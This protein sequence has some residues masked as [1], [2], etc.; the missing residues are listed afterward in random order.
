MIESLQLPKQKVQRWKDKISRGEKIAA[1]LEFKKNNIVELHIID[2]RDHVFI[3]TGYG[4][5]T[6]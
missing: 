5:K 4:K 2:D 6:E 1:K 3:L